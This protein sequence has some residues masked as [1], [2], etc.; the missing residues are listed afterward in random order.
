MAFVAE[1][2]NQVVKHLKSGLPGGAFSVSFA[3]VVNFPVYLRLYLDDHRVVA[4][5]IAHWNG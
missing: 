2:L 4:A 3:Q 5:A 1:T